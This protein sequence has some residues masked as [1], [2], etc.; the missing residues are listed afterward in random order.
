MT[1]TTPPPRAKLTLPLGVAP[2]KGVLE[3][4]GLLGAGSAR[5]KFP[6]QAYGLALS[7]SGT[8]FI[9]SGNAGTCY[10]GDVE[11]GETLQ[12]IRIGNSHGVNNPAFTPDEKRVVVCSETNVHVID[13]A[14][15]ARVRSLNHQEPIIFVAPF[16]DGSILV[17]GARKVSLYA[18]DG[19][20]RSYTLPEMKADAQLNMTN[21]EITAF[22][23]SKDEKLAVAAT[24]ASI[25][26]RFELPSLAERHS[27]L[28]VDHR[29]S[30]LAVLPAPS[31]ASSVALGFM[32]GGLMRWDLDHE[33]GEVLPSPHRNRVWMLSVSR[34]GSHLLSTD[35]DGDLAFTPLVARTSSRAFHA[36][37]GLGYA[38]LLPDGRRAL[39][40]GMNDN[41]VRLWDVV[42][43]R[44]LSKVEGHERIVLA[45]AVT[46]A[47]D[48]LV[49]TGG[50]GRILVW[51]T[52]GGEPRSIDVSVGDPAKDSPVP[53]RSVCLPKPRLAA[54]SLAD[55]RVALVELEG[56][57]RIK[58]LGQ[59][60]NPCI[61]V[62][63][64]PDGERLVSTSEACDAI[65]WDLTSKA[66]FAK[67]DVPND[68]VE[69]GA[70]EPGSDR[71]L[72]CTIRWS[73]LLYRV[74]ASAS[75]K[76]VDLRGAPA[77]GA[78]AVAFDRGGGLAV[79]AG[80]QGKIGLWRMPSGVP[81]SC[82]FGHLNG[83]SQAVPSPDGLYLVSAGMNAGQFQYFDRTLKLWDVEKGTELDSIDFGQLADSVH[84]VAFGDDPRTFFAVT[85]QGLIVQ[86]KIHR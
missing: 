40:L 69:G 7:P 74:G 47:G 86:I 4:V 70:F 66:Q 17:A 26:Y 67:I 83:C 8:R 72:L 60:K 56:D 59:H 41:R 51:K 80:F 20:V 53:I 11:T 14:S 25:L 5:W 78:R 61:S 9:A 35:L 81:L 85:A 54:T 29:P 38:R 49:T 73:A 24:S 37:D 52:S 39:S 23:V 82:D 57:P 63:A 10:V 22:G 58:V 50:D 46:P 34:D 62:A 45:A 21:F 65:V 75:P 18:R 15:G 16:G 2:D 42:E 68:W 31:G 43:Q 77:G 48:R 1:A 71:L 55:G 28:M 84:T 6:D 19:G 64:S 76:Q 36:H 3:I 44:C 27:A 32:D 12:A 30:A 13:L 33:R 79:S